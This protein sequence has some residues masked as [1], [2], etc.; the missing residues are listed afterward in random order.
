MARFIDRR[1]QEE[2]DFDFIEESGSHQDG[3]I[4]EELQHHSCVN[5]YCTALRDFVK[6]WYKKHQIF[7][8]EEHYHQ[9]PRCNDHHICFDRCAYGDKY[10]KGGFHSIGEMAVCQ[11]CSNAIYEKLLKLER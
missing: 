5:E 3:T 4:P 11:D 8:N 9:C 2:K 10:S 6:A 7:Y 1:S